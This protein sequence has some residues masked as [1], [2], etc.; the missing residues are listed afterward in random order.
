MMRARWARTRDVVELPRNGQGTLFPAPHAIGKQQ[1]DRDQALTRYHC[2]CGFRTAWYGVDA[3]ALA[4][5]ARHL[6]GR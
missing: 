3:D 5:I 2:P 1:R 6:E 4:A